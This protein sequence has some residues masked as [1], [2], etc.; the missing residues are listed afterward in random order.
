M[1]EKE[2]RDKSLRKGGHPP[3]VKVKLEVTTNFSVW[4]VSKHSGVPS[5]TNR[6]EPQSRIQV[7]R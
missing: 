6:I 7:E 5:Y 1:A 4:K 3:N 2:L